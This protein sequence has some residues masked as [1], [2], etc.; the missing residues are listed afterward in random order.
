MELHN[1]RKANAK[2]DAKSMQEAG[3]RMN[4]SVGFLAKNPM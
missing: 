4:K 1:L 3:Q 2:M